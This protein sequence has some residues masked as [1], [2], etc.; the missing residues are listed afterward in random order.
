MAPRPLACPVPKQLPR[1]SH[2]EQVELGA[3]RK[4][5]ERLAGAGACGENV[6]NDQAWAAPKL[7]TPEALMHSWL[8]WWDRRLMEM[9]ASY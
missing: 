9:T 5:Q 3:S 7:G 8:G 4:Q 2:A 1:P 6:G